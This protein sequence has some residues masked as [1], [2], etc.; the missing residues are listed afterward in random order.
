MGL[1]NIEESVFHARSP[2]AAINRN[3]Y[4]VKTGIIII[5]PFSP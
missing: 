2:P 4:K 5:R 3:S 1:R